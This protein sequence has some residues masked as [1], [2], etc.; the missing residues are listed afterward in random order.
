MEQIYILWYLFYIYILAF[1][2][3]CIYGKILL[4]SFEK[5]SPADIHSAGEQGYIFKF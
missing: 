2:F 3:Y 1:S 4:L 5:E